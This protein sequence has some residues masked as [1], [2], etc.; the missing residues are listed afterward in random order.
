M[1]SKRVGETVIDKIQTVSNN[2]DAIAHIVS[3]EK[4]LKKEGQRHPYS[5]STLQVE[6]GRKYGFSTQQVLDC[7]QELSATKLTLDL[8]ASIYQSIN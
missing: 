1:L 6:A 5:L 2:T 4:K 3:V 7:M 8:I